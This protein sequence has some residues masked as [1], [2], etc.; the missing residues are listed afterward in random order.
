MLTTFRFPD[1]KPGN[2]EPKDSST[3]PEGKKTT[4]GF[5]NFS[6]ELRV[7]AE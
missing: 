7:F 1:A 3:H 2:S 5:E 6:L 4:K